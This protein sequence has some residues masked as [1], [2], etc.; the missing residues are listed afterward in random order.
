MRRLLNP[1]PL[2]CA[3][4]LGMPGC[5]IGA[6]DDSGGPACIS[7]AGILSART[8]PQGGSGDAIL[9]ED[10][11]I[12]YPAGASNQLQ[13]AAKEVRRYIYL[14][15]RQLLPIEEVV[16]LPTGGSL[17]LVSIDSDPM[18]EALRTPINHSAPSGG[19]II[20]SVSD[21]GRQVLVITGHD[22][23][24]TLHGVYRFAEHLGVRFDLSGDIIPDTQTVIRIDRFDEVGEPM[25]ETRG[26]LPFHDFFQGPD[27]WNT[28]DYMAVIS[29]LPKLGMNFVGLHTYPRWS[30]V[31]ERNRGI[32]QGPE[33]NVWIGLP[34]D[35][36]PDGTVAWSYP[37]YY[38][39][40]GR[41]DRIW[42]YATR[43]TDNF[44]AGASQLFPTS[45]YGAAVMGDTMPSDMASSNA[46]FNRVGEMYGEAFGHA[47]K[48]GVKTAL[49]T[50]L[51][52]GLEPQGPEV[53]SDWVR[54]MPPQLQERLVGM[55][56][57]PQDPEVVKE[58]YRG[59]LQRIMNAHA[60]DYYWLW[61]WE[62]WSRHG[63]DGRQIDA[64]KQDIQLAQEAMAELEV[65][66]QLGLAGWIIGTDRNP[67]EFD[68]ALPPEAPFFG[69]WDEAQGFEELSES[70]V[71]WAATWFEEDW[72]L[73]QPQLELH[74]IHADVS[75]GLD[76]HT[77]GLI[78]KHWRTRMVGPSTGALKD[79][80][81][82]YGRTGSPVEK[83]VPRDQAAWIN[84]YYL[85]WATQQFGAEAASEIASIFANLDRAGGHGPGAI[86]HLLGW[87]SEDDDSQNASPG[88]IMP[89]ETPWPDERARY[90]FVADLES[91][92]PR[93]EG[94]GNRERFDYWLSSFKALRFMG[95]YG[96]LRY[97]FEETVREE[98]WQEA[99]ELRRQL[100]RLFEELMT[101]QIQKVVNSSDL[102]EIIN[103]EVL[104]WY[105]LMMLRWDDIMSEGLGTIPA[106]ADPS[107]E[108]RGPAFVRVTP[109]RTQ[110]Y[111]DETLELTV[112]IMGDPTSASLFYRSLGTGEFQSIEL[113]HEGRAVYSIALPVMEDDFEYY[114][115]AQTP[116]GDVVFPATAPDLNQTVI[117]TAR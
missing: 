39:H 1:M 44:H 69:L 34:E 59:I 105:Q 29:Q 22:D 112:L 21:G 107:T 84:A 46:V 8:V 72:G 113:K 97:R 49:G 3:F 111:S 98:Q 5:G 9:G 96:A 24:A 10:T 70:R 79:L 86:P 100:A 12:V 82:A 36:N 61:S 88:A 53:D 18:V 47:R 16:S 89:R 76:K 4:T 43:G 73:G 77:Q 17:I 90:S 114:V 38:A 75:A 37:A 51:P 26:I 58:V 85:D 117:V 40:T 55:G 67:A 94:L 52:L 95:E 83:G 74:R 60:L 63:V 14:R 33:P 116:T 93:V 13:L 32:P 54:V 109:A 80:S 99:L 106:D 56:M 28:D 15:S 25:F 57:D 2:I 45:S 65:P 48:L 102:G 104:N 81:W 7:R 64:F 91:L 30:T 31:Q 78:A 71:K 110:M 6:G 101:L 35:V 23:T 103:L 62:V 92:R 108:Y 19:F 66:F 87:E 115:E 27:L 42:G 50:E 68:S 11:T 20:K 41:P